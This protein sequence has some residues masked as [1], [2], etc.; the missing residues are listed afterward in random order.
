[1]NLVLIS[2]G[3]PS[4]TIID[5]DSETD[6]NARGFI[7]QNGDTTPVREATWGKLKTLYG[8]PGR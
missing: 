8:S 5:C 7:F 4:V 2:E 6:G 3:G 1:M